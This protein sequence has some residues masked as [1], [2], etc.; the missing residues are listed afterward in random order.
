MKHYTW[1][2]RL[3]GFGLSLA[4]LLLLA[5]CAGSNS[6]KDGATPVPTSKTTA[7]SPAT[8]APDAFVE[9]A[10]GKLPVRDIG[11][12]S[13]SFEVGGKSTSYGDTPVIGTPIP[14]APAPE[15]EDDPA[16]EIGDPE[17]VAA[18]SGEAFVLTAAEW[19]DN[20]NWPFFTNLVNAGTISF[21]SFGIDPRNRIVLTLTD[22]AGNPLDNETAVLTDAAGN[23]LWT[24]RTDKQG[25]AY[26]F[27]GQDQ[28]PDHVDAGGVSTPVT[29]QT[30]DGSGQGTSVTARVDTLAVT[31]TRS[32]AAQ[33]GLQVM[34]LVDTTG[35]MSDEIAYLQKDF[36][37]IAAA[38][39]SDGIS[40]AACFYRDEGDDY[41]T[42]M[43]PFTTDVAAVQG[44]INGEYADGG[45]DMPEAVA[46]ALTEAVSA[47]QGWSETDAKLLF[48]IYDAPPH[49]KTDAALDAAIRSAADQGIRVVPVVASNAD[50]ETELFGRAAAIVTG[51]TY[52]FLTDDSGVGGEHLEPI[53]GSYEVELLHDVIV[54]IINE[55]RPG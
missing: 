46:E 6:A 45:G 43:N 7:G 20:E 38:V 40:Y 17:P 8:V 32:A 49:E 36:S 41:V 24:A 29:V 13:I 52:V 5:S 28:T 12:A 11:D 26:L 33:T 39:G 25:T 9:E 3:L 51:G 22:A 50:R 27:F 2:Q 54:R 23:A 14:D 31:G 18:D 48:L 15:G 44:K 55:N 53:V 35:S 42:R 21:P 1:W 47:A 4:V 19:N 30:P 16:G 34:F 37:D 10:G